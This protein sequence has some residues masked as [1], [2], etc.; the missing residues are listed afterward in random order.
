MESWG[1]EVAIGGRK[2]LPAENKA[3]RG[4]PGK[5]PLP[6]T[7]KFSSGEKLAP[8]DRWPAD[9]FE[10]AEWQRIV[11][12]LKRCGIAKAVHQGALERVCELYAASIELYLAKNYTASRMQSAEYRKTL[13]EFGLTPA[14]AAR[15]GF[16]GG[17]GHTDE[18]EDK[19]P[20]EEFGL[21]LA[22]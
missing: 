6:K 12:D 13:N 16:M 20:A 21:R 11:P 9:G 17:D 3:A 10:L 4:N 2:P 15:V 14:S 1:S 7:P 22:K 5:R 8:P 19:D 18:D